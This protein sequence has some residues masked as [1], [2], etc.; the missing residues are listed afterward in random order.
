MI[1]QRVEHNRHRLRLLVHV[2]ENSLERARGLLFRRRIQADT[3]FLL[4]PCRAIHTFGMAYPIDVVFCD[5]RGEVL[6]IVRKL[7]PWQVARAFDAQAVWELP[8]G[9]ALAL[10]LRIGDRLQPCA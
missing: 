4:R 7:P 3:A 6:D 9:A 8:A 2:C 5:S 1:V 10:G